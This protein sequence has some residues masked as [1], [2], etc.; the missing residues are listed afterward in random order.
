[1]QG[2]A[3]SHIIVAEYCRILIPKLGVIRISFK[4]SGL[5]MTMPYL[6]GQGDLVNRLIAEI[7][8]V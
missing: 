3:Q 4:S 2:P 1:M 7:T 8:R 6:E 5:R